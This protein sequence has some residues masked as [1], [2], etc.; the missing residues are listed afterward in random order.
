MPEPTRERTGSAQGC[1]SAP[2][3][4]QRACRRGGG[5][6]V[7]FQPQLCTAAFLEKQVSREQR[8]RANL[9]TA[10]AAVSLGT[11]LRRRGSRDNSTEYGRA[12]HEKAQRMRQ[13]FKKREQKNHTPLRAHWILLRTGHAPDSARHGACACL[14]PAMRMC[15]VLCARA[16]C[17]SALGMRDR[18]HRSAHARVSAPRCACSPHGR[19]THAPSFAV[20]MRQAC[21]RTARAAAL[22]RHCACASRA[23]ITA[24]ARFRART[25]AFAFFVASLR[26][27]RVHG[28]PR[29]YV[30]EADRGIKPPEEIDKEHSGLEKRE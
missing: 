16:S 19:K 17:K 12:V 15:Q 14:C 5:A 20:R 4:T 22:A 9:G 28:P 21:H 27:R 13:W 29:Q 24:Y 7:P 25:Y 23:R 18:S 1:L 6:D 30:L 26:K 2:R 11:A 3:G 8:A 10:H